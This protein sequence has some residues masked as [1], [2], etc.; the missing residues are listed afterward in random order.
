MS[1]Y[2]TLKAWLNGMQSLGGSK[3]GKCEL[4]FSDGGHYTFAHPEMSIEN[5]MHKDKR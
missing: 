1:G 2:H 5:I 3:D 4:Q